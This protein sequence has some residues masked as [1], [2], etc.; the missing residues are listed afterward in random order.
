MY[1]N[2]RRKISCRD[3]SRS[4]LAMRWKDGAIGND[5]GGL[6]VLVFGQDADKVAHAD[7]AIVLR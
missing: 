3:E 6:E 7:D 5:N 2:K 1:E 4:F